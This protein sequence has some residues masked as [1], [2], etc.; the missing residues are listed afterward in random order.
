M[1]ETIL[2]VNNN[3]MVHKYVVMQ[4]VVIQLVVMQLVVMQHVVSILT[5]H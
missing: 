3:N 1:L 5:L 4:L 2:R